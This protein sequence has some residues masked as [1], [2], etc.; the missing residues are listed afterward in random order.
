MQKLISQHS[1]SFTFFICSK[2]NTEKANPKGS[3]STGYGVNNAGDLVCF[4][5]CGKDDRAQLLAM[6]PGERTVLYYTGKEVTNWPGTFRA[7]VM[8]QN[9]GKHNFGLTRYNYWF[10]VA[11][12]DF[13]GYTIGD[14]TQIAHVRKLKPKAKK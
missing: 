9:T 13:Y 10:R 14:F 4:D 1:T 7:K 3:C 12:E 8:Y 11:G 6:K 2:C 5:C